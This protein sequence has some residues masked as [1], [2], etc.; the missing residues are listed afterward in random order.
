MFQD[1]EGDKR[2]VLIFSE[3]ILNYGENKCLGVLAYGGRD[4]NENNRP[5]VIGLSRT[6]SFLPEKYS[7]FVNHLPIL[8]MGCKILLSD[9]IA[10]KTVRIIIFH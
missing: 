3:D 10:K 4:S 6:N 8:I 5:G 2:S 1:T 7:H 9:V